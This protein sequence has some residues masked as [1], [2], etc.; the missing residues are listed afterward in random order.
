MKRLK[1]VRGDY[2]MAG[3]RRNDAPGNIRSDQFVLQ[4]RGNVL[5]DEENEPS[6]LRSVC[7]LVKRKDGMYLAVS[8]PDDMSDMNMPGGGIEPG[9]DPKD[10]ARRELWE[11]TG[12]IAGDIIEI[13]RKN[14]VAVF[15]VLEAH[16]RIRGSEEGITKWV[17]QD[18]LLYGRYGSFFAEMLHKI[19]L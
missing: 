16:G 4:Q 10:A 6:N 18:E 5:T 12:L 1:E 14:G 9:E 15:K 3:A 13:Y 17:V 8:R 2:T 7:L 11:E 19:N